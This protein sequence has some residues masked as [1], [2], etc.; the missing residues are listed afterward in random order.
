MFIT[1]IITSKM[2]TV[3][4][5]SLAFNDPFVALIER[6]SIKEALIYM[7]QYIKI[8]RVCPSVRLSETEMGVVFR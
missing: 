8:L 5:R 1:N 3:D 6:I 4:R 2:H 7:Y